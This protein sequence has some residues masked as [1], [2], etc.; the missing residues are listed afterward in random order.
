[1]RCLAANVTRAATKLRHIED[2]E[3][4]AA[5]DAELH[6]VK[7]YLSADNVAN[8]DAAIGLPA[9]SLTLTP[10]TLPLPP[11]EVY[12][13]R[14]WNHMRNTWIDNVIKALTKHTKE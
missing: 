14:C 3:Q 12:L 5:L 7:E 10:A 1:M 2:D 6:R 13:K 4:V 11:I 9:G 8:L